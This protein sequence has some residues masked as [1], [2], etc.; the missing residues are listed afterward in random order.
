MKHYNK[1]TPEG[2]KDYI[3]DEWVRTKIDCS[4]QYGPD[5]EF[6]FHG[7]TYNG[8]EIRNVIV[9]LEFYDYFVILVIRL[10]LAVISI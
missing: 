6:I 7:R 3:F 2:T 8:E 1:V 9:N 5:E 10:L 4:N